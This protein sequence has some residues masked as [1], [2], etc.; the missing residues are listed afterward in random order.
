MIKGHAFFPSGFV[1]PGIVTI[2]NKNLMEIDFGCI[3]PEAK[4]CYCY[5]YHSNITVIL[6]VSKAEVHSREHNL[7]PHNWN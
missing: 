5:R 2:S 3:L 6:V 1:G 7:R 4:R